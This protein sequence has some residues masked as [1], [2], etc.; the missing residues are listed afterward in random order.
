VSVQPVKIE[1]PKDILVSEVTVKG[2]LQNGSTYIAMVL[3]PNGKTYVVHQG[4]ALRDGT[5]QSITPQGLVVA[6]RVNDPL[7]T[8]RQREVRKLLRS[9]EEAK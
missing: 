3:A 9:F 4:D 7:S 8:Q 2:V 6:Q 1:G 5:I